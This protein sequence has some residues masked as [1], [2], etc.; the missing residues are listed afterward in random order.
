VVRSGGRVLLSA[1]VPAGPIDA[2]LG[3]MGRILGRVSN[4]PPA[5]RFPWS[6]ATAVGQLASVGLVLQV[7]KRV[8]CLTDR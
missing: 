6:D 8:L 3:A 2:M 4:S 5:Q 1:W 7:L